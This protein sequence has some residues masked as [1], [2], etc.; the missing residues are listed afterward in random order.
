MVKHTQVI[1]YNCKGIFQYS[2]QNI[3][4]ELS[5]GEVMSYIPSLW[6]LLE[7]INILLHFLLSEI[8]NIE[9]TKQKE[10]VI[11]EFSQKNILELK[12]F[13]RIFL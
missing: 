3:Y 5:F 8:L 13:S 4:L 6:I 11:W 9:I 7:R 2:E 1:V 12:P 10:K